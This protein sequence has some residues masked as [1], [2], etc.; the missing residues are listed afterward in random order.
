MTVFGGSQVRPQHPHRRSGR[1][2]SVRARPPARR[3][4]TTRRSRTSRCSRSR[5]A[6]RRRCRPTSQVQPSND[7]RSYRLCSDRLL[8]TGFAPNK[9]VATAIGEMAAAYPRRAAA[10]TAQLAQRQLD[11]TAQ[12]G[13][14]SREQEDSGPGRRRGRLVDGVLPDGEGLRRH[15]RSRRTAASAAWRARATTAAIRTSSARTSGSGPAAR[16][17]RSTHTIVKLTNDELFHIDRRLFTYV[18]A[19]RRE[20]PVSGAL[21]G[22]RPD[23]GARAIHRELQQE[24]RRAR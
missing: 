5:S 18:E 24:P 7:P 1:S 3:A 10:S 8:A 21:P 20:V 16:T 23:A 19:D 11:E 13:V 6:S 4:S 17:T 12:P 14:R 2:V 9:N 22:H 15:R